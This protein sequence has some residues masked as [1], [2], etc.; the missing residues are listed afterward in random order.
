VVTTGER[1]TRFLEFSA[2]VAAFGVFEL[3]GTGQAEPYLATVDGV[4][5]KDILDELLETH[6]R[7]RRQAQADAFALHGLLR[8]EIFADEKLGPVARNIVK[9][10]YVG[11]WYELP[12]A[13]RERFGTS[14]EDFT[15]TVS[16][17]SY[18]EGLLWPTIGAHPNGAKAPGY[19]SWAQPP[20]IPPV[21]GGA[22]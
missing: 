22:G 19:G 21:D 17:A 9:M 16:P 2:T 11:T 15:H 14:K 5:G 18:T 1:L 4:V 10:W 13:W 7:L 6:E 3:Q 12:S 8:R 20:R